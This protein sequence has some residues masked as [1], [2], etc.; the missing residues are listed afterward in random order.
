VAAYEQFDSVGS[1]AT[2]VF[3]TGQ[4][5][6]Q[7]LKALGVTGNLFAVLGAAPLMG[8]VFTDEETFDGHGRAA[9]L[10]YGAWQTIFGS[11]PAIVG[12]RIALSG[13]TYDVV[14]VMPR[15]FFFPGRDVQL[16]LPVSYAPSIFTSAR[17]PHWLGVIARRKPGVTLGQAQQNMAAIARS[18]EQR[19]PDTNTQMG[20]RLET[21][22]GSLAYEPRPALL[23][24]C[25][26]V[27]LLF[28]IVCANVANLQLGR[29]AA[30][31]RELAV[32]RALGASRG[33][34]V[35]QLLTES[36]VVAAA[37]GAVGIAVAFGV[38]AA[39]LRVATSALPLYADLQ[40]DR[41]VVFFAVALTLVAPIAFGIVPA[42]RSSMADRLHDRSDG[43]APAARTLRAALIGVEVA[44][45]VVLV[46]AALLLVRSLL[47]LQ[48][49]D[50]GFDPDR[51]IAFTVT[52]PTARY[53]DAQARLAAFEAIE[54]R[55]RAEAGIDAVGASSTLALRGYTWTGDATVEGRASTDYERELRH[56]SI[57]PGYFGAMGIRLLAGRAIDETDTRDKPEVAVVNLSLARKYFPNADAVGKRITY[58]RP[59]DR[60]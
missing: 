14:G 34:V 19:Y 4:G 8:R 7:P 49:V 59:Q 51:S 44:L 3:L 25:A 40:F 52:L 48:A 18:L 5:E 55:L 50:P 1:G 9:I 10:S 45:S 36:L 57:T 37:G 6:P 54:Q 20:V 12:R 39:L 24:L 17:R 42:L 21:L 35:R 2:D 22:H 47:R 23:M 30:R 29:A 58:G 41:S 31:A 56:K 53:P 27:A 46:A 38:R 15:E 13:R 16:W 60:A 32:R 43:S 28:L 26:A 33:R 11:D